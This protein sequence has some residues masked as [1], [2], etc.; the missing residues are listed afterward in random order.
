MAD[1]AEG[2][3][4]PAPRLGIG[5]AAVDQG[6]HRDAGLEAAHPEREPR[7]HQQS[8]GGDRAPVAPD[9]E[10]AVP[11]APQLRPGGDLAETAP[12]HDEAQPEVRDG[13]DSGHPDRPPEPEQEHDGQQGEEYQGDPDLR[14]AEEGVQVRV[15]DG[16]L[17]G[18]R[19]RQRHGNDEVRGREPEQDEHEELAAPAREQ[20]LEHRDRP[21]TGVGATR[22]LGVDRQGAEQR[23]Q[24]EDGRGQRRDGAGREEGNARLVAEGREVVH[25]REPEHAPPRVR[26]L[27]RPVSGPMEVARAQQPPPDG[28]ARL[29]RPLGQL[30]PER[31]P[32]AGVMAHERSDPRATWGHDHDP[33]ARSPVADMLRGRLAWPVGVQPVVT[34]RDRAAP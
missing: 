32:K 33:I 27:A 5:R 30:V 21:L 6:H 18:V 2:R 11:G 7:E 10:G 1:P 25:A 15:L 22:D 13:D 12:E 3:L 20:V 4:G 29:A 23:H 9:H 14:V 19:G 28:G 26:L 24:D 17:G 16:V 34:G 31:D 8:A